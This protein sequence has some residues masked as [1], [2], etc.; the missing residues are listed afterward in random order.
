MYPLFQTIKDVDENIQVLEEQLASS[1]VDI[2]AREHELDEF[3]KRLEVAR[4]EGL[5]FKALYKPS[6]RWKDRSPEEQKAILNEVKNIAWITKSSLESRSRKS[7]YIFLIFVLAIFLLEGF[8]L[9]DFSW[10]RVT[11]ICIVLVF[12][13]MQFIFEMIISSNKDM[14]K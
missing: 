1:R 13:S 2:E 4:S 10:S 6:K 8:M 7:L 14:R 3:E 11:V 12:L 9:P 5:F